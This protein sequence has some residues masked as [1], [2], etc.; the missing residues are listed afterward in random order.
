MSSWSTSAR[1]QT[2]ADQV[3]CPRV[4]RMS[5]FENGSAPAQAILCSIG[6]R[7]FKGK[8]AQAGEVVPPLQWL[9]T[10]QGGAW[11]GCGPISGKISGGKY[12]CPFPGCG[13]SAGEGLTDDED[14]DGKT[15]KVKREAGEPKRCSGLNV[16]TAHCRREHTRTAL[17]CIFCSSWAGYDLRHWQRHLCPCGPR[18][19][20]K[21]SVAL[22]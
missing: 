10:A 7:W 21:P 16:I 9:W 13:S 8:G 20:H 17:V 2:T 22:K 5:A 14:D 4:P 1:S 18:K 19:G 6:A 15:V 3:P 11:E 12:T